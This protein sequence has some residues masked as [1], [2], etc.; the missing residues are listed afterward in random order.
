MFFF[1]NAWAIVCLIKSFALSRSSYLLTSLNITKNFGCFFGSALGSMLLRRN[2]ILFIALIELLRIR[3]DSSGMMHWMNAVIPF[4]L[5]NNLGR[6][7]LVSSLRIFLS[8][9]YALVSLKPGVS[10]RVI[11]PV[12][13]VLTTPVTD[14]YD[15]LWSKLHAYSSFV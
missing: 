6:I 15:C 12:V 3:F 5:L 1:W 14:S 7:I 2:N 9:R 11:Q 10:I 13:P 8:L 4:C